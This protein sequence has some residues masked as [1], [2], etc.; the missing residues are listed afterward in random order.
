MT[1][2]PMM[3]HHHTKSGY[4]RSAAEQIC[5]HEHS[6]EFWTF[7]VTLTL[8][9]TEQSN[10]FTKQSTLRRCAIKLSSVAKG[11]VVQIIY[12]KA[13]FDYIIHNCDLDLEESKPIFLKHNL[14]Y[15][16]ASPSKFGSKMFNVSE[17]IIWTNIHWHF[18][19]LLWPWPWTQQSNFSKKHSG[20]W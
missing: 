7:S 4:R 20:L 5:P 3:L 6:L 8:T 11:S 10:H 19:I 1:L 13:Y 14:A 9:T 18:K 15:N 12:Q 17:D 16:E 2:W